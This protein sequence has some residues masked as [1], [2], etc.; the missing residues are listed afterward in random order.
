MHDEHRNAAPVNPLPPAVAAITLGLFGVEA[1]LSLGEQGFLGGQEGVGWRTW[2]IRDY[3]LK[4]DMQTWM[5]Q[6]GRFPADFLKRYLTYPII[7]GSFVHMAFAAVILLA[8]G[9]S[10]GSIFSAWAVLAI[11]FLSSV[12]GAVAFGLTGSPQWL[13]GAYPGVF[14]VLGAFTFLLWVDLGWKGANRWRAF[15]LFGLLLAIRLVFGLLFGAGLDWIAEVVGFAT[16]FGLSFI[17]CPGGWERAIAR[18]RRR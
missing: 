12:V 9:K 1:V 2:A 15:T 16:G 13:L 5:L 10:V 6:S 18:I 3:A 14:G 4:G 8:L 11:F 7:H 17:V